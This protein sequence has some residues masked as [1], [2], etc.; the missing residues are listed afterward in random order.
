MQLSVVPID[1]VDANTRDCV[2]AYVVQSLVIACVGHTP[3][4]PI[5]AFR[6]C[7]QAGRCSA[8][9]LD[10]HTDVSMAVCKWRMVQHR[11]VGGGTLAGGVLRAILE[12]DVHIVRRSDA[13]RMQRSI[14][15]MMTC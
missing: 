12:N 3:R 5:S 2:T 11:L 8:F 6:M 1:F 14:A 13:V 10:R 4:F 9:R 7:V 15:T